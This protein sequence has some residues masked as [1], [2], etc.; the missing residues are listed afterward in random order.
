MAIRCACVILG[1]R[2]PVVVLSISNAEDVSGLV[3]PIPTWEKQKLKH[4]KMQ[5]KVR[6]FI[7]SGF[8]VFQYIG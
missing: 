1:M 4:V 8:M 6:V 5:R 2:I 7:M 3:V